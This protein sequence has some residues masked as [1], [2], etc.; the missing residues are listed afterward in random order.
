MTTSAND[1]FPF[2]D[3]LGRREWIDPTRYNVVQRFFLSRL[4]SFVA[5]RRAPGVRLEPWQTRLMNHAIY[6]TYCD[7]VSLGIAKE[8]QSVLRDQPGLTNRSPS[9]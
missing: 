3:R 5:A 7:C 9:A 8:A 4:E 6:S 2:R 1:R